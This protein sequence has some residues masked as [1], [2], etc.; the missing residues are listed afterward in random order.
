MI[1]I[2]KLVYTFLLISLVFVVPITAIEISDDKRLDKLSDIFTKLAALFFFSGILLAII[3]L[4]IF[5]WW[6]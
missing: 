1:I 2:E 3:R 5:I 4:I 6:R